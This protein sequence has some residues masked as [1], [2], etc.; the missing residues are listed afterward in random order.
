MLSLMKRNL[1]F[2]LHGGSDMLQNQKK[3][4]IPI[5]LF[6]TAGRNSDGSYC[7]MYLPA[8][9]D[10]VRTGM[11]VLYDGGTKGGDVARIASFHETGVVGEVRIGLQHCV[12]DNSSSTL[13][14]F[15]Q[16]WAL[17]TSGPASAVKY[18]IVSMH[19]HYELELY[20]MQH[21][22]LNIETHFYSCPLMALA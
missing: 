20:P 16:R 4:D 2:E 3:K 9:R 1:V 13:S 6:Q 11:F 17:A 21:D 7:K 14:H 22:F 19:Q 18:L 5:R 10:W 8:C 15:C 12:C